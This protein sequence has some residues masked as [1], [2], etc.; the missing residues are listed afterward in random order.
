MN[1]E[2]LKKG[3]RLPFDVEKLKTTD[4][5]MVAGNVGIVNQKKQVIWWAVIKKD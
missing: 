4:H 1:M 3:D 5:T 2:L